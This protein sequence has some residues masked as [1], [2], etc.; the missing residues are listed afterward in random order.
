[1]NSG[2]VLTLTAA[3]ANARDIAGNGDA[4]VVI[5]GASATTEYDFDAI[6]ADEGTVTINFAT[7]GILNAANKF[8]ADQDFFVAEN[9][10][11][12]LSAEQASNVQITGE[13]ASAVSDFGGSIVITSLDGAKAYNLASISEGAQGSGSAGTVPSTITTNTTLNSATTLGNLDLSVNSGVVLPLTAAQA[14]ARDVA[15]NGGIIV[16]A[17]ADA[18][19]LSFVTVVGTVTAEVYTGSASSVDLSGNASVNTGVVDVIDVSSGRTVVLDDTLFSDAGGTGLIV[20]GLGAVSLT[21]AAVAT[22]YDFSD[23]AT[24]ANATVTFDDSS[25]VNELS[26]FTGVNTIGLSAGV[27]T[28]TAAQADGV[29]F[30]GT[31]TLEILTNEAGQQLLS[32]TSGDDIFAADMDAST[33]D[34]LNISQGGN[35]TVV[36]TTAAGG[37]TITGFDVDDAGGNSDVLDIWSFANSLNNEHLNSDAAV[38]FQYYRNTETDLVGEVIVFTELVTGSAAGIASVFNF[39]I[40]GVKIN[41]LFHSASDDASTNDLLFVIAND[42]ATATNIWRWQDANDDGSVASGELSLVTALEGITKDD[43]LSSDP[44]YLGSEDFLIS[45]PDVF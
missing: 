12:T 22:L 30:M 41:D 17:M 34:L 37:F 13:G 24:A 21:G 27:T 10:T 25:T 33:V 5:T 3:Q 43:L 44:Q 9:Q 18:T 39:T 15:G 32:G 38:N 14:N 31:G 36:F 40:G 11:L 19:D 20:T 8:A 6:T 23:I 45:R 2:V 1:V 29:D 4:N 42:D 26:V 16:S 7:G 28:L 35:D